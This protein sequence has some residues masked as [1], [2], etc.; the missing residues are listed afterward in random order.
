MVL[1][2]W[3]TAT[4]QAMVV[5]HVKDF[6]C[7]SSL[8]LPKNMEVFLGLQ[9]GDRIDLQPKETVLV[10]N[11]NKGMQGEFFSITVAQLPFTF[12]KTLT[13]GTNLVDE[14][15]C[16]NLVI[17]RQGKPISLAKKDKLEEGD[18]I[19]FAERLPL[20]TLSLKK[21]PQL[22][23]KKD[24]P[25]DVPDGSGETITVTDN[26]VT[27][28]RSWLTEQH[29]EQVKNPPLVA[30]V[31]RGAPKF[32]STQY[33]A[34]G[35]RPLMFLWQGEKE[36]L[37]TLTTIHAKSYTEKNWRE[38]KIQQIWQLSFDRQVG[39]EYAVN[40][41]Y[42]LKEKEMRTVYTLKE[43]ALPRYPD[44]LEK[45]IQDDNMRTVLKAAW[46]ATQEDGQWVFEACQQIFAL[47]EE[48]DAPARTLL[49]ALIRGEI[50][51]EGETPKK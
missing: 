18:V 17:K 41:V 25:Y 30:M 13:Q 31:T 44:K 4:A 11:D 19:D 5:G 29:D 39:S 34:A 46:L 43:K 16:T 7:E 48:G 45:G 12:K 22:L 36:K 8:F 50:P 21:E 10:L 32:K 49:T 28:L 38:T 24:L 35:Q 6:A 47:A 15:K 14:L 26:I 51:K 3:F 37:P 9:P 27:W 23:F 20:V 42:K 33:I 40:F 2:L 1:F